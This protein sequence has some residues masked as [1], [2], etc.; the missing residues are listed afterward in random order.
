MEQKDHEAPFSLQKQ[1]S[2]VSHGTGPYVHVSSQIPF[3]S[4]LG[5]TY[6]FKTM[7][8]MFLDII[9]EGLKH[10]GSQPVLTSK[11]ESLST[12]SEDFD[13]ELLVPYWR[14]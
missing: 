5:M 6:M 3:P 4:E 2:E 11:S 1:R 14:W 12:E 7:N 9:I 8:S 13:G 10:L